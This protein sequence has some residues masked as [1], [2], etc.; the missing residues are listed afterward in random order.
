M[1]K[2][3]RILILITL[4]TNFLTIPTLAQNKVVEITG[5]IVSE[6]TKAPIPFATIINTGK[7][8]VTLSDTAGLFHLTMLEKENIRISA[9]GYKT[10]TVNFQDITPNE[11]NIYIIHMIP[12]VYEM[13]NIDIYK[14]RWNDFEYEF[15]QIKPKKNTTQNNIQ[16]WF[17]TLVS[18][19][20]LALITSATAIGIPIH[21]KTNREKQKI[22][23]EIQKQ[24]AH[25]SEVIYKKYNLNIVSKITGL[26]NKEL[27]NFMKWCNFNTEFL[28]YANDYDIINAVQK[29]FK[30]Y[31]NIQKKAN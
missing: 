8:T 13:A 5:K 7:N 12:K 31:Q 23:L 15:K 9:I 10:A 21:F 4:L 16:E 2:N 25:K 14:A 27:E 29:R 3:K 28:Y 30:K 6:T 20:E 19:E 1:E 26:K 22:K 18:P 11:I 17:Y 24:K